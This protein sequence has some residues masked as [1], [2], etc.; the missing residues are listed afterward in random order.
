MKDMQYQNDMDNK[1]K[2]SVIGF[3]FVNK[4]GQL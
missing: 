4:G 2:V 3:L 1:I